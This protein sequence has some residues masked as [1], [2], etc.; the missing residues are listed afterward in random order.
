M[1]LTELL[2]IKNE[3]NLSNQLIY[4]LLILREQTE[5]IQLMNFWSLFSSL[6]LSLSLLYVKTWLKPSGFYC[7]AHS[8]TKNVFF[9]F[10]LLYDCKLFPPSW[11]TTLLWGRG[12]CNSMK[13]WAMPCRV[14]QD[15]RITVECSDKMWSA[16][17]GNTTHSSILAWKT[18]RTV[19][20]GK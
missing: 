20:K 12:L 5:L 9:L 17:E 11:I 6:S 18:P 10:P 16:G 1:L 8:V 4:P 7:F 3:R 13:R 15:G 2:T 19:W 14:T